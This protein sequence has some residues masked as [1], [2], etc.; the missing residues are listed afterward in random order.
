MVKRLDSRLLLK[1]SDFSPTDDR[2]EILGVFNPGAARA[3]DG[4]VLL[5]RVTQKV[6]AP[7]R[8]GWLHSPRSR[9][10]DGAV[11]YQI[12]ALEISPDDSGDF[13]KPL[14][15]S[16]HRRLAFISHLELVRLSRD[17]YRVREIVRNDQLL[18]IHPWEEYGVEDPRITPLDGRYQIT[19]VTVSE[20]MGVCTSLMSTVDFESYHR[21]GP[22]FPCENKDVVLFPEK[23]GGRYHAFH[24]PVGRI[25]IRPLAILSA[26]SPDLRDWGRHDHVLSC[27]D[28]PGWYSARIGAGT[29]PIR[30]KA[31]WLTIFHGVR[32]RYP[33]DPTGEY[34]A[35]A[36]LTAEEAPATVTG[37]S[38]QPFFLAE[39]DYERV[40]YVSDVVFPT[41]IVRDHADD[42][43]IHVY[44][45]CA[46]ACVAVA[47]FSI[48]AIL[49][50]L[51]R[52]A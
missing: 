52:L 48:D 9:K 20:A 4:I 37:I 11:R 21:H 13:R 43:V 33:G 44:Y 10:I 47:S 22:I 40:G 28:S 41:G 16:G 32:H 46:D 27:S 25:N 34:S 31:G 2:F 14:L 45:G 30:T 49:A 42:D 7:G 19:C 17:G 8:E 5:V 24:R 15:T 18:A 51:K 26:S 1:P 39:T 36:M 12:D 6:K 29:P 35:G 50:S 38:E 3:E 23:I